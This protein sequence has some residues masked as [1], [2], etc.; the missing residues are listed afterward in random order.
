[1]KMDRETK[2]TN[3][4]LRVGDL[5]L[6]SPQDDFGCLVGIVTDITALGTAEHNSENNTDD[7]FVNFSSDYSPRRVAEIERYFSMLYRTPKSYG[8]LPLGMVIMPP[9]ELVC[10]TGIAKDALRGIL[11]CEKNATDYY[12]ATLKSYPNGGDGHA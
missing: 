5:V 1:M 11:E 12:A 2:C 3:G 9:N 7:V 4:I 10:I 8:D 6:S